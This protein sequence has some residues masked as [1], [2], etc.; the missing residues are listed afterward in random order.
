MTDTQQQQTTTNLIP[1]GDYAFEVTGEVMYGKGTKGEQVALELELTMPDGGKRRGWTVL[2]FS[3]DAQQYAI[4]RLKTIGWQGGLVEKTKGAR[5]RARVTHEKYTKDGQ[6]KTKATIEILTGAGF[7]FNNPLSDS[8][9][10]G[11]LA[12]IAQFQPPAGNG[13]KGGY[14]P[15][16]DQPGPGGAAPTSDFSLDD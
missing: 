4:D 1:V 16:W 8:E 7:K 14:P 5:G 15:N 3:P 9:K 11:F 6:T 10:E 12:R 2:F 13:A